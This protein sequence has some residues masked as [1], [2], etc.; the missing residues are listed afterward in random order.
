MSAQLLLVDQSLCLVSTAL[1]WHQVARPGQQCTVAGLIR[2]FAGGS[3]IDAVCRGRR[4][5]PGTDVF[6]GGQRKITYV[7]ETRI[8]HTRATPADRRARA[9][10]H[11]HAHTRTHA[12]THAR[13][14]TQTHTETRSFS[15]SLSLPSPSLSLSLS[16]SHTHSLPLYS[17]ARAA[18]ERLKDNADSLTK[19]GGPID[20]TSSSNLVAV[21]A[22]GAMKN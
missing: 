12:R 7:Y 14:D 21:Q 20:S 4:S 11:T 1:W 17:R 15:S 16:L 9:R 19:G 5:S 8:A 3:Q 6:L 2:A 18:V 10:T 22:R 13:T